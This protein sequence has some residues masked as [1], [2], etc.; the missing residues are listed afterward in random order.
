MGVSDA[1][2][3]GPGRRG[4]RRAPRTQRLQH[5]YLGHKKQRPTETGMLLPNNQRQHRT[6]QQLW[7][8]R[9][10][11]YDGELRPYHYIYVYSIK[12][13]THTKAVPHAALSQVAVAAPPAPSA[14]STGVPRS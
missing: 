12:S 1:P 13:L 14:C 9:V 7:V 6:L 5:R 10:G 2:V 8:V 3:L 4:R 11:G